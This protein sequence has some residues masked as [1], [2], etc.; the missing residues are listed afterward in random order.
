MIIT[1]LTNLKVAFNPFHASSKVPRLF[2]ALLPADAHKTIK[3]SATT[4]PRGSTAPSILELGF[5]DG[6]TMKY[7]WA[8]ESLQK[9]AK[10]ENGS[11]QKGERVRL[12]D[13]AE[14]VNRHARG[15]ARQEE[16]SG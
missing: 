12:E 15:L 2:L 1:Y 4:L 16:L 7:S 8:S 11:R 9:S 6:K 5:K 10:S 14:E 13:I 3:I